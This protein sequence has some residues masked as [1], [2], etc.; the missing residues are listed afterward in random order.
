M[1]FTIN[2][3]SLKIISVINQVEMRNV[4]YMN[5]QQTTNIETYKKYVLWNMVW[6][7]PHSRVHKSM[8]SPLSWI[9]KILNF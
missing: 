6:Y 5:R 7:L 1:R 4:I 2:S 9:C 3:S 8:T